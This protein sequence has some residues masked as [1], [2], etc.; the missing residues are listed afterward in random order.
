MSRVCDHM[1]DDA[2]MNY[3][4]PPFNDALGMGSSNKSPRSSLPN[5]IEFCDDCIVFK[6]SVLNRFLVIARGSVTTGI[7]SASPFSD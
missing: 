5:H 2:A 4:F 3:V 7:M 6:G 1:S